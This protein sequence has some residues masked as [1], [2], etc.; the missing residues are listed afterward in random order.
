[1]AAAQTVDQLWAA[2]FDIDVI[3]RLT[4]RSFVSP[5]L[6]KQGLALIAE[7]LRKAC[8]QCS[9]SRSLEAAA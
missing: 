3:G 8:R 2:G 7:R 1:M 4:V 6:R 5:T 9:R